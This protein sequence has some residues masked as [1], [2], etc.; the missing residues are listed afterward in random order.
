MC[1]PN[2]Q[3][4][5][6]TFEMTCPACMFWDQDKLTCVQVFY[7]VDNSGVCGTFTEVTGVT[8]PTHGNYIASRM[9]MEVVATS[10]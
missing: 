9:V 4:G 6:N 10:K 1:E 5:W 3:G 2:G 8:L 7:D